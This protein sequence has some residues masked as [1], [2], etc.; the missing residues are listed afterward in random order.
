V[1]CRIQL[2][3]DPDLARHAATPSPSTPAAADGSV[4][5]P[6]AFKVDG[7]VALAMAVERA[8]VKPAPVALVGWL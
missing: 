3:S 4:R 6:E 5:P 2:P 1:E 7:I 8:E